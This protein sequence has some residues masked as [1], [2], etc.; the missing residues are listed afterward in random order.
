MDV[1][2]KE[3]A[4]YDILCNS[5]LFDSEWYK[6]QYGISKD[7]VEH[8]LWEGWKLGYN[9]SNKFPTLKYL[10]L[11][12]NIASRNMNPLLHYELYGRAEKRLDKFWR[13][14]GQCDL[15]GKGLEIGPSFNPVCPKRCGYDV[16][17]LDHTDQEGLR[18]KYQE[19]TNVASSFDRIEEV[20]YVWNGEDYRELTGKENYY[21]YI[22]ASHVIEHTMT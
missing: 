17:I 3:K 2:N 10:D 18:Q 5:L 22:I 12:L 15:S 11:Y 21:D 8:Y 16:E 14:T 6:E 19:H 9:P 20:D 13:I 4:P 1:S 7:P